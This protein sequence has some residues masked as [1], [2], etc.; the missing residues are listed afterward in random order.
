VWRNVVVGKYLAGRPSNR[1]Q[2]TTYFRL[3][4]IPGTSERCLVL[5]SSCYVRYRHNVTG[6]NR[7]SSVTVVAERGRNFWQWSVNFSGSAVHT[8]LAFCAVAVTRQ[9]WVELYLH[10][11]FIHCVVHIQ[12]QGQ[13][14]Y[15]LT[16]FNIIMCVR[17]WAG[18]AVWV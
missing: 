16:H 7:V 12:G 14:Y 10:F 9:E 8:Q 6:N 17:D 3:S 18:K 11:V 15:Y 1:R 2:F 5:L 4:H 13:P